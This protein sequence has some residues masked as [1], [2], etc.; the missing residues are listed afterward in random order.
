MSCLICIDCKQIPYVQFIPGL[1][2]KIICCKELIILP[3]DIDKIIEKNFTLSCQNSS[4][5]G[6]NSQ[7]NYF[8]KKL[9]CDI[10]LKKSSAK[11]YI[12]SELIPN[13][14][15]E[16]NKKYQYYEPQ[17]HK[18]F[19]DYC[20]LPKSVISVEDYKKE[21]KTQS[22]D[23]SENSLDIIPYFSTLA[24]RIIQTYKT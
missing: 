1:H 24:K 7:I 3:K 19:C 17:Q 21:I 16:H 12:Q 22:I 15:L 20:N 18:L 11:N 4:C 23:I 5:T 10:C 6:K 14:C 8:S 13:T 2:V 9:L